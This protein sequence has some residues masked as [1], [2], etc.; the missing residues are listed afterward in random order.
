MQC[1]E[2]SSVKRAH[3]MRTFQMIDSA[4][5]GRGLQKQAYLVSQRVDCWA[6]NPYQ[7]NEEMLMNTDGW[8]WKLVS[9]FYFSLSLNPPLSSVRVFNVDCPHC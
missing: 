2:E 1:S 5:R 9:I 8:V 4:P 7:D 3:E 6:V